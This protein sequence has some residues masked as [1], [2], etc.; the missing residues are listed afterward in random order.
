MDPTEST[1][2]HPRLSRAKP[3][4]P[5]APLPL[6]PALEFLRGLGQLNH[7]LEKVSSRMEKRLGVTAQQRLILRCIG[8]YPGMR[9]G[10]LAALLHVDPGTVSA[11]LN[12]LES[13]G[14][15]ERR[16]D[17]RDARRA[18]IGLTTKGKSLNVG[19]RG[20]VESA[21]EQ[22]LLRA[23]KRDVAA[24]A[25]VLSDLA[26]ALDAELGEE[27]SVVEVE[28]VR[29]RSSSRPRPRSARRPAS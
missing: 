29:L 16:R 14:L 8:T 23:D 21:V 5:D 18:A 4:G 17:P 12:R 6:D 1:R 27:Q 28:L 20:T 11:A 25:N 22:L 2:S 13:K 10:Q 7:A 26:R 9:A 24:T 19:T 15:V 3:L